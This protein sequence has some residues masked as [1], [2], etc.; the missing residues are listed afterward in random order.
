M[1]ASIKIEKSEGM[2]DGYMHYTLSI[3]DTHYNDRDIFKSLKYHWSPEHKCWIND[4]HIRASAEHIYASLGRKMQTLA[5]KLQKNIEG[6]QI[7]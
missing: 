7:L 4:G 3:M 6:T 2:V 5:D 1:K